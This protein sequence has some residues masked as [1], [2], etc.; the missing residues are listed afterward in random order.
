M[1]LLLLAT[2]LIASGAWL[3]YEEFAVSTIIYGKDVF[4]GG[5][6]VFVGLVLVWE[7]LIALLLGRNFS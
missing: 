2:L 4:A 5:V 3:L 7:D 6:L 1:M